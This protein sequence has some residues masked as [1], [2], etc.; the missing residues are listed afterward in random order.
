L[1]NE[2]RTAIGGEQKKPTTPRAKREEMG[3]EKFLWGGEGEGEGNRLE[4]QERI[5]VSQG[6][7]TKKQLRQGKEKKLIP[8]SR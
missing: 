8:A 5:I 1:K 3:E 6:S 7:G 4:F 2:R